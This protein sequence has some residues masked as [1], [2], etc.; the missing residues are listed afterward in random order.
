[1]KSAG[2]PR[3]AIESQGKLW[4]SATAEKDAQGGTSRKRQ[5]EQWKGGEKPRK[6][7]G[8]GDKPRRGMDSAKGVKDA[9]GAEGNEHQWNHGKAIECCRI[10]WGS[11]GKAKSCERCEIY[12]ACGTM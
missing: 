10:Q 2:Q 3:K 1:M 12:E 4:E 7:A 11:S 5:W 6:G 8:S 9:K